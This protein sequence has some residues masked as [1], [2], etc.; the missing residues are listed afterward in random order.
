MLNKSTQGRPS[1]STILVQSL[2]IIGINLIPIYGVLYLDW[3]R[4]GLVFLFI[5]E[6]VIVLFTDTIKVQF[7]K[8]TVD[9]KSNLL[10]ESCFI[11]F[12]GFFALLVHGPYDS[13]ESLIM[14][15]MHLIGEWILITFARP[16]L[17]ILFSRLIRLIQDLRH[18]GAFGGPKKQPLY[19]DSGSW[20]L[21]LFFA[22]MAAP[23]I[24][25][26]GPNPVGGLIVLVA[27]KMIGELLLIWIPRL[28][29]LKQQD[30]IKH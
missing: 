10:F 22:V 28:V 14:D 7:M 20:M 9:K 15:R 24:T 23:L 26:A 27:L 17:L 13:L 2:S 16:L 30:S 3:S 25:R 19:I 18:A 4:S 11:L 21:L 1:L 8:R 12:F 5:M 6:G 29:P